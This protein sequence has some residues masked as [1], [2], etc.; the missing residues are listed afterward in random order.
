MKIKLW[1][2][3]LIYFVIIFLIVFLREYVAKLFVSKDQFRINYSM[4]VL[5]MFLGIVIGLLL[6]LEHF[7]NEVSKGGSWKINLPKLILVGVP[8]FYFSFTNLLIYSDISFLQN[9]I[10]YPMIYL[11]NHSSAGIV[12]LF[13]PILG[14]IIITSFHKYNKKPMANRYL[15]Y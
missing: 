12:T 3:Y 13:Q 11:I 4:I 7:M 14:Y 2:K 6:G 15:F 5:S 10:A 9:V 1:I 8:S